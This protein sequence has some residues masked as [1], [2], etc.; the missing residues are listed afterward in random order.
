M[1]FIRVRKTDAEGKA[2]RDP[3]TGEVQIEDDGC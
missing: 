3:A 2:I 1:M